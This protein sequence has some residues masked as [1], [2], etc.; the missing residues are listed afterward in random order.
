MAVNPSHAFNHDNARLA[1]MH[2]LLA[3]ARRRHSVTHKHTNH[4]EEQ[5]SNT[6]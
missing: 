5:T 4:L 3:D 1:H 2:V 6:C